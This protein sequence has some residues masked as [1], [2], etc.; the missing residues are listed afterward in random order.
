MIVI[1]PTQLFTVLFLPFLVPVLF[2]RKK[3]QFEDLPFL[4]PALLP[5]FQFLQR[6][7]DFQGHYYYIKFHSL[8]LS[9]FPVPDVLMV[10]L[11]IPLHIYLSIILIFCLL[12][13]LGCS[14]IKF[15]EALKARAIS[16]KERL[17]N[18][19]QRQLFNLTGLGVDSNELITQYAQKIVKEIENFNNLSDLPKEFWQE[20]Y[21]VF[22]EIT[23]LKKDLKLDNGIDPLLG[24]LE[25]KD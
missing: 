21:D 18:I 2:S 23:E 12:A 14:L 25:G 4:V 1:F 3:K 15:K 19:Q 17:P 13:K 9:T 24:W 8:V 6:F 5:F 20:T 16:L 7:L 22:K 11:L 10:S